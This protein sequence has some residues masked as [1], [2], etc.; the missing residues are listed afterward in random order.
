[1]SPNE[2]EFKYLV[3]Y[4]YYS[5]D[6]KAAYNIHGMKAYNLKMMLK[7]YPWRMLMDSHTWPIITEWWCDL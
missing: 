2:D 7:Q 6:F 5:E 4:L 1:M 3:K